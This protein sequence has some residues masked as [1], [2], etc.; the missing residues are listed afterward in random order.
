MPKR[1]PDHVP[2]RTCA[3]CREVRPKRSLTRLVRSADGSVTVDPTGKAAGRGTYV[4]DDPA[5]RE[6]NRLA[7]GVRRA[8]GT[9]VEPGALQLEVI[10]AAT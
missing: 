3:V 8:L 6:P 4:C 7:E 1:R 2:M 10:D 9:P 5:C